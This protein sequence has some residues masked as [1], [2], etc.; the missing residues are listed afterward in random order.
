MQRR[1]DRS[2]NQEALGTKIVSTEAKTTPLVDS[3]SMKSVM[4]RNHHEENEKIKHPQPESTRRGTTAAEGA[5]AN[6]IDGR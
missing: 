2:F 5:G 1:I 6:S 3:H 4:A